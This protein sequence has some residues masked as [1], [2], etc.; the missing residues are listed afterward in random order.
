M[1]SLQPNQKTINPQKMIT[2]VIINLIV[3]G[4]HFLTGEKYSGPLPLFVNGYLI[5]ILLPFSLY[6]LAS[7]VDMKILCAWWARALVPFGIG[8]VVETAQFFG[9]PLFGRTFDPLDLLAYAVGAL[10]AVLCDQV[11]FPS[12]L[13]F[14]KE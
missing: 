9:I 1:F 10:L 8:L 6:F 7:L 5:D 14:W 3:G 4:L 12:L 13:P 2:I 11:L